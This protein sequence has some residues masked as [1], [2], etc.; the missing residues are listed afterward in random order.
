MEYLRS[1]VEALRSEI[2]D[3]K[4]QLSHNSYFIEQLV[5]LQRQPTILMRT[6][7]IDLLPSHYR[8]TAPYPEYIETGKKHISSLTK[9]AI[10]KRAAKIGRKMEGEL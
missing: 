8:I 1:E 5:M 2:E 10:D 3:M 6:P 7:A 4:A 9:E